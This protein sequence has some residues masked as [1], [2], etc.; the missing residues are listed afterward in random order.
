MPFIDHMNA[1]PLYLSNEERIP[2]MCKYYVFEAVYYHRVK[3]HHVVIGDS[4]ISTLALSAF[5]NAF[6]YFSNGMRIFI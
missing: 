2:C 5:H 4:L 3:H 6:M 1:I